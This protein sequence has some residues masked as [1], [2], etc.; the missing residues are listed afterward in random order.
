MEVQNQKERLQTLHL[1][2]ME[3]AI[4]AIQKKISVKKDGIPLKI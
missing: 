1:N 3:K 2:P 4:L